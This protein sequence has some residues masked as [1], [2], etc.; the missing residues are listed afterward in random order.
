MHMCSWTCIRY[1]CPNILSFGST[2]EYSSAIKQ[3]MRQVCLCWS[4]MNP[5]IQ[6]EKKNQNT[7]YNMIPFAFK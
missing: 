7:A 2:E 4:E 5:R 6:N 1:L 3:Y